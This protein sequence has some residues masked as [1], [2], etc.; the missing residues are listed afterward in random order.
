MTETI[1]MI[2]AA[3]LF[4]YGLLA[5]RIEKQDITAPMLFVLL[6][7][8]VGPQILGWIRPSLDSTGLQHIAELTLAL[9]L[10]TDASQIER[11][12]LW[13]YEAYPIRLLAVGLPLSVLVG[14]VTAAVWFGLDWYTA[15]VLAVILTP[16]DA[17]LAQSIMDKRQ[18][19]EKLRQTIA[20]ESGLN[21]GI[22]LPILLLFV[23]LLAAGSSQD[24]WHWADFIGT[25]LIL[26]ALLGIGAGRLG[27]KLID[28]AIL[29]HW[30]PPLYQRLSS[31]ALG[32]LAFVGTEALEGNGF[33]AVFLAGLFL[34]AERKRVMNRLKEFGEAEGHLLSLVIFFLFGAIFVPT[35]WPLLTWSMLVYALL[36]LTLVRMLPVA[37]S[38]IGTPLNAGGRAFLA[39]FGPRGIA[40]I[41]YLLL[42]LEQLGYA[43]HIEHYDVL[44]GTSVLTILLSV[45][46]HGLSGGL[47]ANVSAHHQRQSSMTRASQQHHRRHP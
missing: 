16:T 43:D 4:G 3:A 17:A 32:I 42:S 13:R 1:I 31:V 24:A 8:V 6:G 14:T 37:I 44:F 25:Q 39:W 5:R 36:S 45:F 30:M 46:L 27:G 41:L 34:Q 12:Q 40:S 38:L 10:F 29:H 15:A 20:V 18:F 9:V 33:V 22:A 19:D 23:S 2:L 26:G 47:W 35:A 11:R 28:Y 7:I 21:D